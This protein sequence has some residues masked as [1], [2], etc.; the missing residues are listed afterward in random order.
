VPHRARPRRL[1]LVAGLLQPLDGALPARRREVAAP[2]EEEHHF[3]GAGV[4]GHRRDLHL[5]VAAARVDEAVRQPVAED[6]DQR[7]EPQRLVEH[8]PRSAPVPAQQLVQHEQRVAL[9]GVAAEHD[10]RLGGLRERGQ[11]LL[12][13]V[14][15]DLDARPARDRAVEAAHEPAQE[16]VV[17]ALEPPRAGARTESARHPQREAGEQAGGVPGGVGDGDRQQPQAATPHDGREQRRHDRE[18][19][20]DRDEGQLQHEDERGHDQPADE[21]RRRPHSPSSSRRR[22][23]AARAP[24]IRSLTRD[25]SR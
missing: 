3:A 11:R 14:D 22:A 25:A 5:R 7:V 18:Q 1:L 13:A 4:L 21:Q 20:G 23:V 17:G 19:R 16:V 24:A 6:V 9:A 10:R 15:P 12:G 8:Q 2:G